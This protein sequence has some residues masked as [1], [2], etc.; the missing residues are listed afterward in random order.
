MQSSAW[1]STREARSFMVWGILMCNRTLVD[2][3]AAAVLLWRWGSR[4]AW[5]DA[6]G[7]VTNSVEPC[8]GDGSC[9]VLYFF[10]PPL[11]PWRLLGS[12]SAVRKRASRS[13]QSPARKILPST[14]GKSCHAPRRGSV[15]CRFKNIQRPGRGRRKATLA[16][17][18]FCGLESSLVLH[19][20]KARGVVGVGLAPPPPLVHACLSSPWGGKGQAWGHSSARSFP[21]MPSE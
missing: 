11:S 2:A 18:D 10:P 21:V 3:R 1:S 17:G 14:F 20:L 7:R 15:C 5:S 4:I 6:G 19:L 12:S 13:L 8:F 16:P 9:A